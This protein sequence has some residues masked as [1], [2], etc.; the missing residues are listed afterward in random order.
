MEVKTKKKKKETKNKGMEKG[1]Y[2]YG[3]AALE[4]SQRGIAK[5]AMLT[6]TVMAKDSLS[7]QTRWMKH[8]GSYIR[9]A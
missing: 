7:L 9:T 3:K 8:T 2:L 1:L 6:A 4:G 5:V